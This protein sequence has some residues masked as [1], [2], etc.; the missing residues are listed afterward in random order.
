MTGSGVALLEMLVHIIAIGTMVLRK[1]NRVLGS[2]GT[3]KES[4]P[5]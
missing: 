3:E 2:W 5:E 1:Q 4:K